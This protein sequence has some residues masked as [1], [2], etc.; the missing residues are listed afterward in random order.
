[1]ETKGFAFAKV[2]ASQI[3]T[4]RVS[5]RLALAAPLLGQAA[6]LFSPDNAHD[7]TLLMQQGQKL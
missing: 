2:G 3:T 5:G 4:D 6:G 7:M 1:L